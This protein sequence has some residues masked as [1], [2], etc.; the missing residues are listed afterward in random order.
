[1]NCIG[2]GN[3]IGE[4]Q[5]Y[6]FRHMRYCPGCRPIS[7]KRLQ[8]SSTNKAER[9]KCVHCGKRL[10]CRPRRLCWPCYHN[11]EIR[12]STDGSWSKSAYR[13]PVKSGHKIPE[14]TLFFPGT[15]EKVAVLEHRAEAGEMLWHPQDTRCEGPTD[16]RGAFLEVMQPAE[17]ESDDGE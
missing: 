5:V 1:M 8:S 16:R 15:A 13:S 14:P 11:P 9:P 17:E 6:K 3:S 10:Q 12:A 2:C 7:V 4:S